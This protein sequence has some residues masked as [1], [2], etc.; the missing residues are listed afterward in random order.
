ML[1]TFEGT[2]GCGK[3]TLIQN[4]SRQLHELNL[5]HIVTREPGGSTVAEG[6]RDIILHQEMDPLTELFLYEAAR[7]EHF[8]K[9]IAPALK[10]KKMVL[11]DRFTDSTVAYQ[12]YARG[13]DLKQIS[14]LNKIA[15]SNRTP[16]LTFF[17]DLP[18]E[19]GLARAK[20]PN[21]FELA[22]VEFQKKVRRGFLAAIK[23]EPKRFRVIKV[24][25]K[26]PEQVSAEVFS[27]IQK[28]RKPVRS[29]SAPKRK[30]K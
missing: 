26:T 23:K 14:L 13:L 9:T 28:M 24:K 30:K 3:S 5:A 2:E 16:D 27:L 11:C 1:I 19:E 4:L 8:E 10:A 29:A 25:G 20:D 22:G 18:V 15:T 21:K 12:G 17:L 7:A 6:I